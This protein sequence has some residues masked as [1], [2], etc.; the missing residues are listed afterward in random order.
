MLSKKQINLQI[1]YKTFFT[2]SE[3]WSGVSIFK[4][5]W[6]L[7]HTIVDAVAEAVSPLGGGSVLGYANMLTY[8]NKDVMLSSVQEYHGLNKAFFTP[9]EKVWVILFFAGGQTAGQQHPWQATLDIYR[10]GTVF[11]QQ[12]ILHESSTVS[13]PQ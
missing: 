10:S 1:T 13:C 7:E 3:T 5:I 2:R 4:P 6:D 12:P 8:R 9:F 11:S